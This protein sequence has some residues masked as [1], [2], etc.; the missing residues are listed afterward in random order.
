MSLF[1]FP[2]LSRQSRDDSGC[3]VSLDPRGLFVCFCFIIEECSLLSLTV[4]V[5]TRVPVPLAVTSLH[6]FTRFVRSKLIFQLL[7]RLTLL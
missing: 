1:V 6:G 2:N 4:L 3:G 5:F 7:S